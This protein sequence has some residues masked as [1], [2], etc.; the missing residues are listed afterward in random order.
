MRRDLVLH[1]A[2][3]GGS[4]FYDFLPPPSTYLPAALLRAAAPALPWAQ[5]SSLSFLMDTDAEV[6]S[7]LMLLHFPLTGFLP[8][9]VRSKGRAASPHLCL[10]A[11]KER[12]HVG[13][14]SDL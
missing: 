11:E 10:T 6:W 13:G 4:S 1:A 5:P 3:G 12:K 8:F 2:A 9:P 14:E 7:H